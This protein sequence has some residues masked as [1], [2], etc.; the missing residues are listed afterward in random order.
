MY[1]LQETAVPSTPRSIRQNVE[2]S[3]GGPVPN[4]PEF[5]AMGY[6]K[7]SSNF[8]VYQHN[9]PGLF[10]ICIFLRGH[11]AMYARDRLYQIRG[12][13]IF[14]T[15]PDEPH[16]ALHD[17]MQPCT[18]YFF[19]FR[20]PKPGA[21]GVLGLPEPESRLLCQS[22]YGLKGH[23]FRGAEKLDPYFRAILDGLESSKVTALGVTRARAAM[24]TMLVTLLSLPPASA[25]QNG[26]IPPGIKR[27][28][29]FLESCPAP[30]PSV[31]DLAEISGMSVSHFCATFS[32]WV[33]AAPLKFSHHMRLRR[34]QKLLKEPR[35]TVTSVALR[36]GYCS[37]QHL[38]GCFK[39]YL[40]Q[41]PR[42]AMAKK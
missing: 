3:F 37:S 22:I 25:T 5:Q 14:L 36:L 8:F 41:T 35:A 10:E 19:A 21:K 39:Q 38:A 1:T 20:L 23:H 2:R 28:R 40:G 13:D 17:V 34:A 7:R 30:W 4:F 26:V 12:G 42:A 32:L 9:H 15:R 33:G 6:C 31:R 24:Q 11:V 29:E 27:A 16:G 18:H